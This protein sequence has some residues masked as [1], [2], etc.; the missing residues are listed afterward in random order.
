MIHKMRYTIGRVLSPSTQLKFIMAPTIDF[1][2]QSRAQI[3]T[4][5]YNM[6]IFFLFS[7]QIFPDICNI[8]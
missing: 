8:K 1:E 3:S 2:T 6:V 4:N 7:R 5:I